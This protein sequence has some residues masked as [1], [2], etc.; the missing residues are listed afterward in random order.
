MLAESD[1]SVFPLKLG[2]RGKYRV[3]IQEYCI[4]IS[5]YY[6]RDCVIPH[7]NSLNIIASRNSLGGTCTVADTLIMQPDII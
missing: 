3:I 4:I 6:I 2:N 7:Q 5:E 1:S